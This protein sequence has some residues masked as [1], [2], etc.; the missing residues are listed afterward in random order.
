VGL[1]FGYA[2]D[3]WVGEVEVVGYGEEEEGLREMLRK[4]G[5]VYEMER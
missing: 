1:G 2:E 3:V 4:E 5:L